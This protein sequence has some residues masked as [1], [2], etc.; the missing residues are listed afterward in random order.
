MFVFDWILGL[1]FWVLYIVLGA[2]FTTIFTKFKAKETYK[3]LTGNVEKTDKGEYQIKG[4]YTYLDMF[5]VYS[6]I[7]LSF[8]FWPFLLIVLI[9]AGII[10]LFGKSLIKMIVFLVQNI[11]KKLPEISI[12]KNNKES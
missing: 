9:M 5:N 4:K 7:I 11:A 3:F 2:V 12:K 10:V 1:G 6:I 8:I